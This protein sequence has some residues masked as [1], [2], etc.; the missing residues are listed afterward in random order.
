MIMSHE[1]NRNIF[2]GGAQLKQIEVQDTEFTDMANQHWN[3]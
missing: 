3:V 1:W 2:L